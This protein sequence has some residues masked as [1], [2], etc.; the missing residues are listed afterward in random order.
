MSFACELSGGRSLAL[1]PEV[2][3]GLRCGV[4]ELTDVRVDQGSGAAEQTRLTA[5][6]YRQL[7]AGLA[8]S[9]I[10]PLSAAR[11]LYKA[12]GMD[13][14]RHR[15]SSEALLRRV[16]KG[17]DLYR[18]NS[19]VD[20]CNLASLEFLLPVGMYDAARI[21]G[22][23]S[24]RL[25]REGDSYAGIR[26]GDVNVARRLALYDDLGPFG[27]PTSDSARTCVEEGTGEILAVI[28]APATYA[29]AAMRNHLELFGSLFAAHCMATVG[30]RQALG[31][32]GEP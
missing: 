13:P 16:L 14:S 22:D 28:F 30:T 8:P 24:L 21:Q 32:E 7:Y 6:R 12:F 2:R 4:V 11:T 20:S 27:S 23:V 25:G 17:L 5:A 9:S 10:A 1:D 26:K 3:A 18:I 15:P 31:W 19:A 29:S